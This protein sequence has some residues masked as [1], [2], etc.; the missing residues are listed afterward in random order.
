MRPR[1]QFKPNPNMSFQNISLLTGNLQPKGHPFFVDQ[2]TVDG[3]ASLL[4]EKPLAAHLSHVGA[5]KDRLGSAVGFFRGIFADGLHLRAKSIEFLDSF[6]SN[7]K[8]TYDNLAELAEKFPEQFGVSL[9]LKYKPVWV[10]HDGSEVPAKVVDGKLAELAP[11]NAVRGLPSA[12]VT[13]IPS[14]DFVTNPAANLS[15]L[16]SGLLAE[17]D[18]SPHNNM[19]TPT[20]FDQAA[21]DAKLAEQKT[22]LTAELSTAHQTALDSITAQLTEANKAKGVAET[23]L[24]TKESELVATLAAVGVKVEK[25]DSATLKTA[26]T[27]RIE[28]EAQTLL[29]ARGIK[30]LPAQVKDG[31]EIEAKLETDD[32]IRDAY[33]AMQH[34]SKESVAFLEKHKD[35]IWRAHTGKK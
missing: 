35:A 32:Q 1:N 2:K 19:A 13:A 3:A 31:H 20:N 18:S 29:A 24:A 26:L 34:G 7:F 33:L 11:A 25:T 10:M 6:K 21:V 15:G 30:P 8:A 5:D 9:H 17:I 12:R 14:G 23:A 16:L 22:A 27:A 4:A 28:S